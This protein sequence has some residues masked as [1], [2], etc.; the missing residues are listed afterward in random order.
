MVAKSKIISG[1]FWK[2]A[3]R[4]SAQAVS[5]IVSIV[6]ARLLSPEDYGSIAI[7]MIFITIANVFVSSGFGSALIQKKDA[8]NV[9]FSTV[10]YLNI[11]ISISIYIVIFFS[12]PYIAKFYK[13]PILDVGLKVL[14]LRIIVAAVNSVQ[15]AYVSRHML[16]RHFFLATLVGTII[17]GII[18]VYLAY[19]GFGVWALICQYLTNVFIDTIV[20]WITVPWRPQFRF[21]FSKAR[22]LFGFGWKLLVSGLIDTGYKQLRSLIIG[23]KY[24]SSDLAFYNQGDKYPSLIVVNIN[25]SISSV[26]FPVLSQCQN[27]KGRLKQLTRQAIQISSFLLWPMMIGLCVVSSS[28]VTV[29][30]TEKWLP[31]VPYICVFCISYGLWP[32]HTANLQAINAIGRSDVYLKLEIIKKVI[33]I[34]SIFLSVQYGPFIMAISL[35]VTDLLA[36]VVNAYPNKTLLNYGF[37]E[38]IKDMCPS[39]FLAVL[40]GVIIYPIRFVFNNEILTILLQMITGGLIYFLFAK[41]TKQKALMFL[42]NL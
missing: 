13:I 36:T 23:K 4:I 1:F 8:D 27:E 9:D 32:I 20:L 2:F 35:L 34:I 10:F 24:S 15:Q 38:Q 19:S 30:L 29:L 41:I 39:F 33:G 5:L 14:G 26:L 6:L 12:A 22:V 25:A 40:M 3:E 42:F 21:S 16:F 31:C 17:S 18:G 37:F 28:L 7:V 11:A